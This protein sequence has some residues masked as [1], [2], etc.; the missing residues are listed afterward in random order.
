MPPR[1]ILLIK[2]DML[3]PWFVPRCPHI[4]F[5]VRRQDRCSDHE[6]DRTATRE[7]KR[8]IKRTIWVSAC[9]DDPFGV[10]GVLSIGQLGAEGLRAG[11]PQ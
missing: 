9:R 8:R 11:A 2:I 1:S 3:P 6:R 4:T 5:P 10:L 7:F